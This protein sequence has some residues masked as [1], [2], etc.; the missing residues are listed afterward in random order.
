VT[1]LARTIPWISKVGFH[2]KSGRDIVLVMEV[3]LAIFDVTK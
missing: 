3:D 1:D 2:K